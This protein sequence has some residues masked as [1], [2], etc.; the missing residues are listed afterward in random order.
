MQT[1]E[2]ELSRQEDA[3]EYAA[4]AAETAAIARELSSY[5]EAIETHPW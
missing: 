2:A 1:L 5:P 4:W 3:A